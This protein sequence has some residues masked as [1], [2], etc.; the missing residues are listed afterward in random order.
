M[1]RSLLRRIFLSLIVVGAVVA[2]GS[3]TLS[4]P[5]GIDIANI[6]STYTLAHV[7]ITNHSSAS[8]GSDWLSPDVIVPGGSASFDHSPGFY[9]V[10]AIDTTPYTVYAYSVQVR[11]GKTVTLFFNGTTLN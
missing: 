2:I 10:S 7:Y 6:S 8:W 11:S 5:S 4:G 1:K 3:C 9:D